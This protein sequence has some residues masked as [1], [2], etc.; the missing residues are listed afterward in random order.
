MI[1]DVNRVVKGKYTTQTFIRCV[2]ANPNTLKCLD[3][4]LTSI[5]HTLLEH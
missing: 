4:A 3:R 5:F 2:V 1:L